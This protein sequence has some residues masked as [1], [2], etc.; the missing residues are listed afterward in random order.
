MLS[1][2]EYICFAIGFFFFS[3]LRRTKHT[4]PR[5]QGIFIFISIWYVG[6]CNVVGGIA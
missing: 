1:L 4:D 2:R 3:P 6:V 5:E